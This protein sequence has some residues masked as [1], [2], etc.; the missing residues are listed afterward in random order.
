MDF[1][2]YPEHVPHPT[3]PTLV[4]QYLHGVVCYGPTGQGEATSRSG[5]VSIDGLR[6]FRGEVDRSETDRSHRFEVMMG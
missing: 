2:I 4:A 6:L 1:T 5:E 3:T